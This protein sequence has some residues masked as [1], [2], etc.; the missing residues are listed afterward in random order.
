MPAYETPLDLAMD[1]QYR[2]DV[3]ALVA[4]ATTPHLLRVAAN[5]VDS[6][7]SAL[8]A[9]VT[10]PGTAAACEAVSDQQLHVPAERALPKDGAPTD[11]LIVGADRSHERTPPVAADGA[12]RTHDH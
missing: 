10:P 3:V 4:H 1:P 6:L 7:T 8:A 5:T 2:A 12:L 9:A 11:D